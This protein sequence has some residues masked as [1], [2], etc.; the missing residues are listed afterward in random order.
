MSRN[1]LFFREWFVVFF[2]FLS[3]ALVFLSSASCIFDF[4]GGNVFLRS[5]VFLGPVE[6]KKIQVEVSGEVEHPGIYEV[7]EGDTVKSVLE[8]A[9]LTSFS[10]R[11]AYQSRKVLLASC[12]IHVP[13]KNSK[14]SK[15][16]EEKKMALR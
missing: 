15:K 7:F 14:K 16:R 8:M 6:H 10:D 13:E 12:K 11:K 4:P 9:G 3:G 5:D 1:T 2:V